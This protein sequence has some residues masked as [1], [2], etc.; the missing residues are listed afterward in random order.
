MDFGCLGVWRVQGRAPPTEDA[1]YFA[2][3]AAL[4]P[5]SLQLSLAKRCKQ[6]VYWM[7]TFIATRVDKM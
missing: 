6:Q 2:P 7:P 1:N 4:G 3:T 5:N